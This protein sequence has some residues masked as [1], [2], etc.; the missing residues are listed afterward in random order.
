MLLTDKYYSHEC[1]TMCILY[2][3]PQVP[4]ERT[5]LAGL[6]NVFLVLVDAVAYIS[7]LLSCIERC[8]LIPSCHPAFHRSLL[9][10]PSPFLC[11]TS[12]LHQIQGKRGLIRSDDVNEMNVMCDV[13]RLVH[14]R[15]VSPY[16][17]M[18]ANMKCIH[19]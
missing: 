14:A 11:P 17:V 3:L 9:L 12:P 4:V 15:E 1:V 2:F 19:R 18:T 5:I 10:F 16:T 8:S 7:L 13:N 6:L